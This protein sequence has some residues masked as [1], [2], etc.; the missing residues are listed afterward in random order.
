[1]N[2]VTKYIY[3]Q[4]AAGKLT[5]E[6][7][8]PMIMEL[9]DLE[10]HQEKTQK[11]IAIIGMACRFP[12]ADNPDEFWQNIINQVN[13]IDSFPKARV[14]ECQEMFA[15]SHIVRIFNN[16]SQADLKKEVEYLKGGYVNEIDKFDAA[17]F[18][19]TPKEAMFMDPLQRVFLEVAYSALEDAGYGGQK[20][21]GA[22]VGVF[23]GKDHTSSTMYKYVTEPDEMHLTGSWTGIL[24]SRISYIYN[25]RGP[26]IVIDTACSSGLVALH[27]AC[28]SLNNNECEMAIAGGIHLQVFGEIKDGTREMAMVESS[29]GQV[30][31]FDKDASGTV[32]GEGAG[33]LIIKPLEKAI[34]NRD[35][36]YAVIKG[37][38]IN[39]DGASSGGVTA[40]NAEAQKEVII[41]AWKEAKIDPETIA[42]IESHGTG[43]KLGDPIEIK[44][45][46]SAFEEFTVKKQFCGI[47]SVKTNVGHLVAASGLASAIKVVLALKNK[48]LPPSINFQSPN[49]YINFLH[50]PVY[51]S[52]RLRPW[53]PAQGAPRRAGVSAFGFSG[54]N[55]HL[56]L[57]E[58]PAEAGGKSVPAQNRPGIL[59]ISA[60][61]KNVLQEYLKRYAGFLEHASEADL[62]NI[63]YTANTGR[64]HYYFRIA[65]LVTGLADL[66]Q[67]IAKLNAADPEG[68]REPG[69]YYGSYKIV[70]DNKKD[71]AGNE[72]TEAERRELNSAANRKLQEYLAGASESLEGAAELCE[73]YIKGADIAWDELYRGR[74][75]RKISL[76]VYPLERTKYWAAPNT[77]EIGGAQIEPQPLHPLLHKLLTD[78]PG[79]KIYGTEFTIDGQW[80][81]KE[82]R[83]LDYYIAPGTTYLEMARAASSAYYGDGP[84]ELRDF[85]FITPLMV[86]PGAKKTV[87]TIVKKESG[88]LDF[89]AASKTVNSFGDE[90]WSV[91]AQG[92]IYQIRPNPDAR[93]DLAELKA[94]LGVEDNR[95]KEGEINKNFTFGPRWDNLVFGAGKKGQA[96]LQL[97]LPEEFE[98]DLQDYRIHP[99]L[100]DQAA[101]AFSQSI[102]G[103]R[104]PLM[105]KRMAVY[106]PMPSSFYCYMRRKD[107]GA[108][109]L[110]TETVLLDAALMDDSG[111]VFIEIEDYA[112]KRV[113]E[114]DLKFNQAEETF[115]YGFAWLEEELKAAPLIPTGGVLIFKD[116]LG[117]ADRLMEGLKADGRELIE[118]EPGAG[119]EQIGERKFRIKGEEAGYQKLVEALH[120]KKISQIL[121]LMS[122][123]DETG[124]PETL[125]GLEANLNKGLYSLFYLARALA[126]Y[127][128]QEGIDLVLIAANV[129]EVTKA[130]DRINPAAAAF[131]GLGKTVFLENEKLRCRAI[132]IDHYTA[133]DKIVAEILAP[134]PAYQVAYRRNQR[135]IEEFRTIGTPNEKG[136]EIKNGPPLRPG[137]LYIITGGTGG[138]G[139]EIGKY[140]AGKAKL[141]LAL[142]SRTP[143]PGRDS[144][145]E[146][147]TRD[148]D[149][150]L[151]AQIKAIREMEQA[152]S[153]VLLF[154][155]D[156]CNEKSLKPVLDELRQK[157]GKINGVIHAAGTAGDGFIIRKDFQTFKNVISPKIHGAW[158]LDK[159]TAADSLDFFIMFSSIMAVTG[160]AGQG[161]YTAANSYL[162][163]FAAYR[164]RQGKRTISINWPLWEGIGMAAAYRAT[165]ENLIFKAVSPAKALAIFEE[166]LN[167]KVSRVIFGELNY[168]MIAAVYEHMPFKLTERIITAIKKQQARFTENKVSKARTFQKAAVT[169]IDDPNQQET[170]YILGQIWANVLGLAEIDANDNFYNLGGDSILAGQLLKEIDR[171]YPEV[172]TISDI[173][174]YST[175]NE[176]ARVIQQR[177]GHLKRN[178]SVP[179]S[180]VMEIQTPETLKTETNIAPEITDIPAAASAELPKQQPN[181]VNQRIEAGAPT[182]EKDQRESQAI[183]ESRKFPEI[184]RVDNRWPE[185]R[186]FQR[187]EPDAKELTIKLQREIT[188][189]LHRC[190]PL[191]IILTDEK[192]H[193]WFYEHFINIFSQIESAG[194][195]KLDFLEEWAPFRSLINEVSLGSQ[196][197]ARE[198]DIIRFIIDNINQ[199]KYLNVC[200]DEYYL[201]CRMR[202]Q[203]THFIHHA[204]VYGYD[205]RRRE[206][207]TIGFNREN[208]IDQIP[209]SY[210]EFRYAYEKGKDYYQ[211]SAPWTSQ[212]AVQLFYLNGFDR[213]YPFNI[214]IFLDKLSNYLHSTPESNITYYWMLKEADVEYGFKVYDVV[215]EYT[216]KI[217]QGIPAID[218][219][220]FHLL[221][222][223]K[224]AI[225]K[226]LAYIIARYKMT[227]RI[228]QLYDAYLKLV[229]HFKVIRLKYYDLENRFSY[230]TPGPDELKTAKETL[231]LLIE[232]VKSG[233]EQ[234]RIL[235]T[236]IYELLSSQRFPN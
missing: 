39:N 173:F 92:K 179:V 68:I 187:N 217:L 186:M 93:Y 54:T 219:R 73:F 32:W 143:M 88:Y 185:I 3:N 80:V 29:D 192:L 52:D 90:Q 61:S 102:D 148:E 64:G 11:E 77:R 22:N 200:V 235:L 194:Y 139:L 14:K 25:F 189:A 103:M 146:I 216:T 95:I 33:A 48:A 24:A 86:E 170:A 6:E 2:T 144:W 231:L 158:L 133:P 162:D 191:Q 58:A 221:Y 7:A 145:D 124:R 9:Q 70:S 45:L 193:P 107:Q 197:M 79:L 98:S 89:T 59:T 13:C 226:R 87:Q 127:N 110:E 121:H 60:R 214:K 229:E 195:L 228:I 126:G 84:I 172:L 27:E 99:A 182:G 225:A 163:S 66:K 198:E 18:R 96:L 159:L 109:G 120:G 211:E 82:H 149:Q 108:G 37:S 1:M 113:K 203:K 101:D 130:E 164:N 176:Q 46:T 63:C 34:L 147:L 43:T 8:K 49:P 78:S 199:G 26:S 227:G 233:K 65:L 15:K 117:I 174:S 50:S 105:Y 218:Y 35:H 136:N 20:L 142:I 138:I 36:I 166:I 91:H 40:P 140:L 232:M 208:V 23:V 157:S 151:C 202:F 71:R 53:N 112:L 62:G 74:D 181:T 44:G 152:G 72:L 57:E 115:Y 168:K 234:E 47:G 188:I 207:K 230:H 236:E 196:Y 212:T 167:A 19:I 51:V 76:P 156:I 209:I 38:A 122:I 183:P 56:V 42:Y 180:G 41:R 104:L 137:G 12:K 83:V 10:S 190:L 106:G 123:E 75:F 165:D 85:M 4:V 100:M 31:T 206:L 161:D 111:Q 114:E 129:N 210:D 215:I 184:Y 135:F 169:G 28:R 128:T 223:H 153:E 150:K 134:G 201:P 178:E 30:R 97:R 116:G 177:G 118:V 213:P 17:F 224:N 55:C 69:I 160:G 5:P 119:F 125:T 94:K 81:L 67:K 220:A 16:L 154:S 175:I 21:Y 131:F 155:A 171:T 222:E 132:D 141:T 204:L 205:N